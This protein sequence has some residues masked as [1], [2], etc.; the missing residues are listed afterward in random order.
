MIGYSC[1]FIHS[2]MN[3]AQRARVFHEFRHGACQCL[4]STDLFT[5]G[6]DIK[7]VNVVNFDIPKNS[8]ICTALAAPVAFVGG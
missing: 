8:E 4:V 7:S 6:I 5:R 1:F 2:Y 3:E